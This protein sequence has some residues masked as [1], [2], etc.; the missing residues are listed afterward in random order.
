M[1]LKLFIHSE[2]CVLLMLF[3]VLFPASYMVMALF[4]LFVKANGAIH[5]GMP[6]KAYHGRTG[7]V[8]NVAKH[9][10]GVILS[11]NK[12]GVLLFHFHRFGKWVDFYCVIIMILCQAKI[13]WLMKC[14]ENQNQVLL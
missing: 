11:T 10:L 6:Y 5:K 3:K 4:N 12:S 1:A 13:C 14:D 2:S 7:Q 9:S 8:Y